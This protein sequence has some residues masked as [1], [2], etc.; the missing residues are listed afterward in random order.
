MS[1]WLQF[2]GDRLPELWLRTGEHILLTG[3]ST[4]A[5]I[6]IAI[7]L[8]ISAY[9]LSWLRGLITGV[10]GVLQTIPSLAMLA[11]L[12]TAL[13][14]IGTTPALIALALYALLPIVRNTLAGLNGVSASILEAAD[15]IGMTRN[16][17]LWMVELPLAGPFIVT[18]IRTAAVV[19]VGI[20]TLSAFIG[21]GGLGQF[22]NRG[23]S[24]ANNQLILLGAVPSAL[25]ALVVDGSIGGVQWALRRRSVCTSPGWPDRLLRTV[26]LFGPI[27]LFAVGCLAALGPDFSLKGLSRSGAG[28]GERDE[29]IR[30]G[31][32]NFTE[33]LILG[34]LMAQLI[35]RET[36][37]RV[38][39]KFDLGGTM[40]CHGALVSGGI[41]LYAEY[42]GTALTA[43]LEEE[44]IVDPEAAYEFVAAEYQRKF[45]VRWLKPFG[46]NNTYAITVREKDA[47]EKSLLRIS[48]LQPIANAMRAG[49]TFEFSERP[50]GYIGLRERYGFAF[51]KVIDLE[52]SLMYEAIARGEVDVISAFATDGRIA[53]YRLKPLEDD[54]H[55]FPPYHAAPVIRNTTLESHPEL[56]ECLHLLAG[57]LSDEVMR[58]LNFQVDQ[59]KR[60]PGEVAREFL[61]RRIPDARYQPRKGGPLAPGKTERK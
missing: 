12:L 43:V 52:A 38:L 11:F 41:D 9:R 60:S 32:K 40:I 5:A 39:R 4:L 59:N 27:L 14:T 29:V 18:G 19:G 8:G 3:I 31:S 36:D 1:E 61:E 50:D 7:P 47:I 15:G 33:Q 28:A 49:W 51:G 54:R 42:T 37:L 17:R 24:L 23:L 21:A 58:E 34:E 26:A 56:A 45:D 46:F 6:C 20:A 30:V 35:E 13:G 25:L 16:Q 55:F 48:D 2:V 10:V 22:I 57:T 44:V 53:A